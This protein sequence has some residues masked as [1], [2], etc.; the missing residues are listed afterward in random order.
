MHSI[1][2]SALPLASQGPWLIPLRG[3]APFLQD[4]PNHAA[5]SGQHAA[6]EAKMPSIYQHVGRLVNLIESFIHSGV[7]FTIDA[8]TAQ[9]VEKGAWVVSI[10]GYE[11]RFVEKP[12]R[13]TLV[14]DIRAKMSKIADSEEDL[15]FGGWPHKG[16]YYLD[17]SRLIADR[18]KALASAQ[19]AEQE[20]IF[21][22]RTGETL[23]VSQ[24]PNRRHTA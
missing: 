13:A 21:H 8:R 17:L 18:A 2:K 4:W 14:S 19:E 15:Y 7:G 1:L 24:M 9:P 22:M 20:A 11:T 5:Q 23:L 3:E 16:L 10:R 12:T 6:K